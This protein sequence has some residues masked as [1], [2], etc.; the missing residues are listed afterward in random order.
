LILIYL[1]SS[2][3]AIGIFSAVGVSYILGTILSIPLLQRIGLA[4][5]RI[6]WLFLRESI[7]YSGGIHVVNLLIVAPGYLF[8]LIVLSLSGPEMTAHFYIAYLFASILI[9]IPSAFSTSLFV[10]GFHGAVLRKTVIKSLTGSYILLVPIVTLFVV[11]G[12]HLL[13]FLGTE[14]LIGYDLMVALSVSCFPY[15]LCMVYLYV[16]K[17]LKDTREMVVVAASITAILFG[18]SIPLFLWIGILGIGYGWI[19]SYSIGAIIIG[20]LVY[21]RMRSE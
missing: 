3:G 1:F 8:P 14:Y 15:T 17:L 4:I 20:G 12:K 13:G 19:L 9:V 5:R 21:A 7:S 2:A 10:E 16:K 18:S 6:D 11:F